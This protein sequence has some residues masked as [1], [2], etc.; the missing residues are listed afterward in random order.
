L[1]IVKLHSVLI[2][3]DNPEL[4]RTLK[5]GLEAEGYEVRVASNGAQALSLQHE[6]PADILITDLFM[7]EA[8]GFE[9]IAGF[10]RDFPAT[11]IVAIS[12]EAERVT[13]EYLSVATLVGVDAT[14]KKPFGMDLLLN[15]LS[16]LQ[17]PSAPL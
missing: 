9:A 1:P 5:R 4:R 3:D 10:R 12:G 2:A 17:A 15:V 6:S 16:G 7:P 11:R 8:D 14:V 13:R